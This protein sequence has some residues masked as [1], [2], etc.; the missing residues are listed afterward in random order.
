M[1]CKEKLA[2]KKAREERIRKAKHDE[3]RR[4]CYPTITIINGDHVSS[5]L[6]NLIKKAVDNI[7]FDTISSFHK[8]KDP[9]D[10]LKRI[11]KADSSDVYF[12]EGASEYLPNLHLYIWATLIQSIGI[13]TVRALMP[14]EGFRVVICR[15]NIFVICKKIFRSQTAKF[16]TFY[17]TNNTIQIS[18]KTYKLHYS[19]HMVDR[20]FERGNYITQNRAGNWAESFRLAWVFSLFYDIFD[21]NLY[22]ITSSYNQI[23]VDF[24]GA[25]TG[26]ECFM[27]DERNEIFELWSEPVL[28]NSK[29]ILLAKRIV[30]PIAIFDAEGDGKYDDVVLKTS[31]LPGFEGTLEYSTIMRNRFPYSIRTKC[32][33]VLN[34]P[35]K[36]YSEEYTNVQNI[37]NKRCTPQYYWSQDSDS[38]AIALRNITDGAELIPEL[39]LKQTP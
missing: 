23:F 39:K 8:D 36:R 30:G 3:S 38:R 32:L 6:Y 22:K 14:E 16:S 27:L 2:K 7:N 10:Y 33:D 9:R 34:D 18:K 12:E 11:A 4:R 5:Y 31:L 26:K 1:S 35:S 28:K 13:G 29:G 37:F 17:N 20:L 24:F 15:Q 21:M 25:A 19:K